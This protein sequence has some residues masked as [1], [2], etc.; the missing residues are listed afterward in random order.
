MPNICTPWKLEGVAK[1]FYIE[2]LYSTILTDKTVCM[3]IAVLASSGEHKQLGSGA[4]PPGRSLGLRPFD[5]RE[6]P[7][8]NIMIRRGGTLDRNLDIN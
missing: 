3:L 5:F 7:V 6:T 1:R 8:S 2:V 4:K